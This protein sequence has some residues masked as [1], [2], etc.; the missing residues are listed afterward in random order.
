MIDEF[1]AIVSYIAGRILHSVVQ[2][3]PR[4]TVFGGE[5]KRTKKKRA[6]DY[7]LQPGG[8][9]LIGPERLKIFPNLRHPNQLATLS[10][11][12]S[13]IP[14]SCGDIMS[15]KENNIEARIS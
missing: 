12:Q 4:L 6:G 15:V 1:A 5:D 3:Q 13:T 11:R 14:R 7:K 10:S 2:D 8:S 9:V